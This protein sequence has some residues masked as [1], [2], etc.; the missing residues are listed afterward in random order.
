LSTK[1]NAKDDQKKK[2]ME[3]AKEKENETIRFLIQEFYD[4][5]EDEILE[6]IAI[7]EKQ[8]EDIKHK[9][10]LVL[11]NQEKLSVKVKQLHKNTVESPSARKDTDE[12]REL[13]LNIVN[14]KEEI[15]KFESK[16]NSAL[17]LDVAEMCRQQLLRLKRNLV[18]AETKLH[19]KEAEM[20]I[21]ELTQKID[22]LHQRERILIDEIKYTD[23]SMEELMI[24]NTIRELEDKLAQNC[25]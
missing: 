24:I 12:S 19:L 4:N 7:L 13:N 1:D 10:D 20:S 14:I 6:E 9:I 3:N 5:N 8:K 15:E 16:K 18:I 2:E 22:E 21:D 11:I 25:L 17:T 23:K